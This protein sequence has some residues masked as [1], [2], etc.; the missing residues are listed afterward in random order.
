MADSRPDASQ[1]ALAVDTTDGQ[2]AVLAFSGVL[3]AHALRELEELLLDPRLRRAGAWVLEMRAVERIDLA[4]AYAVL[5]AATSLPE[6]PAVTV[7][8]ARRSVQRT[9][10]H[11]GVDAVVTFE[12]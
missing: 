6:T 12:E 2:R 7:R 4:C 10:R 1:Y 11:A 3:D 5:R 8:G 9:L